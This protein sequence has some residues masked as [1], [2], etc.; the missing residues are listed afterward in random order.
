MKIKEDISKDDLTGLSNFAKFFTDDFKT[1]F[2][3]SGTLLLIKIKSLQR[4]N[5]LNGR[6]VGDRFLSEI[7]KYLKSNV[8][9]TNYRHE[10]NGF[11]V[12]YKQLDTSYALAHQSA[13][14]TILQELVA[15]YD[16]PF[17]S[18]YCKIIPYKKP[19][20]SV[21][22]YYQLYYEMT[23]KSQKPH[24][25]RKVLYHVLEDLSTK[26]NN[27]IKHYDC[28]KDYALMDEVS[29]LPNSKCAQMFLETIDQ[30]YDNYA[31][32]LIDGDN[33]RQY[34]DISY[35]QGN[36]A[37]RTI[38]GLIQKSIRKTDR[39]FRW[40]CGDEFLVVACDIEK[41]DVEVLS[42]R[43]RTTVEDYYKGSFIPTTVSLGVAQYPYDGSDIHEILERAEE[44]NRQAKNLGKN[45]IIFHDADNDHLMNC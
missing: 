11:L 25:N 9:F 31:I 44:A 7:G 43:I 29:K 5:E 1:V 13:L 21:A 40:L 34:N 42:E 2:G 35:S 8:T 23:S 41:A 14:E 17:V 20:R 18:L 36:Y 38:A 37:I 6:P 16:V 3:E 22:D 32:I 10:G 33:L 39:V 15:E 24:D 30:K 12:V 27:M 45:R 28:V 4:L 26:V 19:I